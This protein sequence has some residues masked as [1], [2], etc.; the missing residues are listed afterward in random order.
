MTA[1]IVIGG[2]ESATATA[3]DLGIA[4]A[5]GDGQGIATVL[6][7]A[8]TGATAATGPATATDGMSYVRLVPQQESP[9][10][11][12]AS[13]LP[14]PVA[15]SWRLLAPAQWWSLRKLWLRIVVVG[16]CCG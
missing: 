2:H 9:V 1:V 16:H 15:Q 13:E 5:I 4:T 8:A 3:T 7:T 14:S 10:Q 11:R 6:T 12:A